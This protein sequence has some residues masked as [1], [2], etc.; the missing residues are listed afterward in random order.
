MQCQGNGFLRLYSMLTRL[1]TDVWK[2]VRCTLRLWKQPTTEDTVLF[3]RPGIKHYAMGDGSPNREVLQSVQGELVF[4]C[5]ICQ[6]TA[7]TL[8]VTGTSVQVNSAIRQFS[9]RPRFPGQGEVLIEDL[10]AGRYQKV[11]QLLL[12]VCEGLDYYCPECDCFYCADHYIVVP[13]FEEGFYD[14]A[15][16]T[17]P[18]GHRRIIDD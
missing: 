10:K 17:C 1:I 9:L 12:K 4:R 13:A 11:H 2:S 15:R 16:A 14:C 18:R 5:R 3:D 8:A 7:V 6:A